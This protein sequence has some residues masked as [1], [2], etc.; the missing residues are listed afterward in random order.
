MAF[1]FWPLVFGGY[2]DFGMQMSRIII[3]STCSVIALVTLLLL[4]TPIRDPDSAMSLFRGFNTLKPRPT[5]W[6][7]KPF[8]IS[9]MSHEQASIF[10]GAHTDIVRP[11]LGLW[12][13]A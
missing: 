12:V 2:V 11:I 9:I 3:L 4:Y 6:N 5:I 1:V 8:P 13:P 10:F 7:P